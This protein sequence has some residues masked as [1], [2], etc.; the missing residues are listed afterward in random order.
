MM[1]PFAQLDNLK[2][3]ILADSSDKDAARYTFNNSQLAYCNVQWFMIGFGYTVGVR[4][5]QIDIERST[6]GS[7]WENVG[8]LTTTANA[9]TVFVPVAT[10]AS[11]QYMRITF[12]RT[13]GTAAVALTTLKALTYRK[14]DQGGGRE[15]AFPFRWD[16][17]KRL[18]LVTGST[19]SGALVRIGDDTTTQ[20]GG[21]QFGSDTYF[22]REAAGVLRTPGTINAQQV[23]AA[24]LA[25]SGASDLT[26]KD[27][28]DTAITGRVA[29]LGAGV[30]TRVYT[31]SG[32]G[33]D[34]SL[35]YTSLP[36]PTTI[37]FRDA[38]GRMQVVDGSAAADIATKGQLDA[39]IAAAKLVAINTQLTPYTLV[40]AD[41]SKAVE[42][43]SASAINVTVP[44]NSSVAFPIGTVIEITQ[45][46]SGKV[47]VAA[48]AGVTIN[49]AVPSMA[50]RAQWSSVALRKRGTDTW[51][52]TGDMA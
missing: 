10:W 6:D 28:V 51:L 14:G 45:I 11:Y 41:G 20:A 12:T 24:S 31:R 38:N 19:P 4:T 32:A 49:S 50:T 29:T 13:V 39:D 1:G 17:S 25:P 8:T 5:V 16:A 44:P 26:R 46:G 23:R 3:T 47:T 48:G 2:T 43:N 18:G 9:S 30:N 37:P 36:T 27:Y 22:F 42:V 52:L 33:L 34:S 21:M 35:S 15:Y 7:T 40:L